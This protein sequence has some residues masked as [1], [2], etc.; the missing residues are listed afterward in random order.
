MMP[1]SD[2]DETEPD[3]DENEGE[4]GASANAKGK[5]GKGKGKKGKGAGASGTEKKHAM[6][7]SGGKVKAI[8]FVG[9]GSLMQK[10]MW[11]KA[12]ESKIAGK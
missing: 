1:D 2:D 6:K 10:S 7:K 8:G 3:A 4:A 12:I 9:Q 11:R 5:K